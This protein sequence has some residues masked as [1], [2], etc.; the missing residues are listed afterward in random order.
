MVLIC[1]K[2]QKKEEKEVKLSP[3]GKKIITDRKKK[4]VENYSKQVLLKNE[5]IMKVT[6]NLQIVNNKRLNNVQLDAEDI[7]MEEDGL[8][9]MQY[10]KDVEKRV[11]ELQD[12][13][14]KGE[15]VDIN[16]GKVKGKGKW[17][18]KN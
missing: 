7:A 12:A 11:K 16:E 15:K 2:E 1:G 8:K 13:I 14:D 4:F 17:P 6:L 5:E 9:F 3:N 10:K 18:K